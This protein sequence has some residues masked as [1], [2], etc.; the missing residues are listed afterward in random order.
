MRRLPVVRPAL[1]V[2]IR[3]II[4]SWNESS[5]ALIVMTESERKTLTILPP[6]CSGLY[7]APSPL[8]SP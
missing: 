7:K 3:Q 2:A 5:L 1:V 4:A 6:Q 8:S